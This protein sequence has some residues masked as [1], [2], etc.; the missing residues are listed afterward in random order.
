MFPDT[1]DPVFQITPS[2]S[3]S[4]PHYRWVLRYKVQVSITEFIKSKLNFKIQ[5]R[6]YTWKTPLCTCWMP[7]QGWEPGG[8]HCSVGQL[9]EQVQHWR[10]REASS[11]ISYSGSKGRGSIKR[12]RWSE[13]YTIKTSVKKFWYGTTRQQFYVTLSHR[14]WRCTSF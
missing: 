12:I 1:M 8:L 13:A 5:C 14:I 6:P 7:S 11:N 10:G 9:R 2:E 3:S 4:L